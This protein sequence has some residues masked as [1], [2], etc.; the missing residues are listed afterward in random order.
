MRK[1][2]EIKEIFWSH[3]NTR[4]PV[5]LPNAIPRFNFI[6]YRKSKK[7]EA[8]DYIGDLYSIGMII[9]NKMKT[10]FES[11]YLPNNLLVPATLKFQYKYFD[12]FWFFCLTEASTDAIDFS[13]SYFFIDDGKA[14]VTPLKNL[15]IYAD[16]LIKF[17]NKSVLYKEMYKYTFPIRGYKITLS[18]DK[19]YDIIH[20]GSLIGPNLLFSEKIVERLN[21]SKMTNC[22]F[23]EYIL[24]NQNKNK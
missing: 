6:N 9:S 21:S 11:H 7:F 18:N 8:E 22:V 1:N 24:V 17:D 4:L 20:L 3:F 14:S 19:Y 12:T 10:I 16:K 15:D 13:K 23:K 5:G 2:E